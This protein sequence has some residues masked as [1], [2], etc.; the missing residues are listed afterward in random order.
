VGRPSSSM[1]QA[2]QQ[3][4]ARAARGGRER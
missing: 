3:R 4:A 1:G 2:L